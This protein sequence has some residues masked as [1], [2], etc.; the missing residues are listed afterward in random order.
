MPFYPTSQARSMSQL[1]L[2]S[3]LPTFAS[4]YIQ[5]IAIFCPC[6]QL[7]L[8]ILTTE[9]RS[10]SRLFRAQVIQVTFGHFPQP[11]LS[12]TA[13]G[14]DTPAISSSSGQNRSAI[15]TAQT[16]PIFFFFQYRLPAQPLSKFNLPPR[17][18]PYPLPINRKP[19]NNRRTTQRHEPQQR[20]P[21]AQSNLIIKI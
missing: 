4:S 16:S 21:P 12:S 13:R 8:S 20:I 17:I 5:S 14:I 10:P 2:F 7:P 15:N 19:P 3:D 9:P 6:S 11:S 1:F 18:H